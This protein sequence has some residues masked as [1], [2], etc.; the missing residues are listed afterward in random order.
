MSNKIDFLD[1]KKTNVTVSKTVDFDVIHNMPTTP[2][3][4]PLKKGTFNWYVE[5]FVEDQ[6]KK[7]RKITVEAFQK[8]LEKCSSYSVLSEEEHAYIAT[9][10]EMLYIKS[11]KDMVITDT[12]TISDVVKT[13]KKDLEKA[14]HCEYNELS[15]NW[16]LHEK[17]L[18]KYMMRNG[19]RAS[20]KVSKPV[21]HE[22]SAVIHHAFNEQKLHTNE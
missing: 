17:R 8:Y 13:I 3:Y 22:N 5:R 7:K 9:Q 10:W 2:V 4:G 11:K 12:T 6:R 19:L 21:V 18:F 15:V 1:F 14:Y 16:S 20:Q